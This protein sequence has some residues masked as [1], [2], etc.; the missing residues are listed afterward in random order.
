M[1]TRN[2][3]PPRGTVAIIAFLAFPAAAWGQQLSTEVIASGFESPLW[4][5]SP[6]GDLDR[7]FVVEQDSGLIKIIKNGQVLATPFL[8]IGALASEGG[9]QGLLGMAF[10]PAFSSNE[11][12]FVHYTDVNSNTR[13]VEYS[14]SSDPD[15]ANPTPV[16]TILAESQPY[17]N[18]K[19][20]NLAFGGDGMLYIGLGDGGSASDP[21]NRAQDGS[22]NLGKMLRLDVDLP[23]PFIPADNPF[24]GDPSIN[25]EIWALGLR[26]PWRYSFDRLTGDLYIGDVGQGNREEIDFQPGSSA[27]GENYGWRCMEG[28]T[29]TGDSGCSCTD[30]SLELP[31][32]EYDHSAGGCSVIGGYVYRGNALSWF[33]GHYLFGDFCT[34]Q[35]WSF[36]YVGG[37]ITELVDRTPELDPPGQ[38]AVQSVTSFGEDAAGELY[39]VDF[40]GGEIFKVVPMTPCRITTYCVA[41]PNST[42]TAAAIGNSGSASLTNNDLVLLATSCP[43]GQFGVFFYGS[44]QIDLPFGN[45]HLCVAGGQIGVF[46][47]NPP[48]HISGG[49]NASYDVDYTRPPMTS[50]AGRV[51]VGSTWNFQFWFRDPAGGGAGFDTSD[52]LSVTFCP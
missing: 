17:P 37:Q 7:L 46:R 18:H 36:R 19:G 32:H 24:V 23:P 21:E 38:A 30:P 16:Q 8:N 20:G 15:V 29:C 2:L 14:V 25:D 42:G 51:D 4:V 44:E 34:G 39:I 1:Q 11:R 27:G 47:L 50:G 48:V 49:G 31:I 13:V 5:G 28:S 45:G 33:Q 22:T 41:D 12:F 9:E 6:P 52:A 35:L 26:N 3:Q 43:P 40:T 10:H